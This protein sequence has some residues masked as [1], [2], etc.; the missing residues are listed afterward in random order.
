MFTGAGARAQARHGEISG[1]ER[2]HYAGAYWRW[3]FHEDG[4]VS[5]LR[6]GGAAEVMYAGTIR[7]R[8]FAV[9]EHAFRYRIALAYRD[10]ARSRLPQRAPRCPSLVGAEVTGP[11]RLLAGTRADPSTRSAS[12]TASTARNCAGSSPR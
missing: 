3:G 9:R 1:V 2:T 5:A 10:L 6:V 4:V 8:R 11:I 7:H 12:T